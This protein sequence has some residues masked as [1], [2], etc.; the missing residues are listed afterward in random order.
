[1]GKRSSTRCFASQE[2]FGRKD[3]VW[4]I[5]SIGTPWVESIYIR[6]HVGAK[7]GGGTLGR[8]SDARAGV[9]FLDFGKNG[10]GKK[11]HVS[12]Q[13]LRYKMKKILYLIVQR[14]YERGK[15]SLWAGKKKRAMLCTK[16]GA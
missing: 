2:E 8:I 15:E 11:E 1:M 16:L 14:E 9:E 7:K 10:H 4:T 12:S 6:R 13:I 5:M 3:C